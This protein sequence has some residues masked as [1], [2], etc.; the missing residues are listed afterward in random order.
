MFGSSCN[1]SR[2]PFPSLE[3]AAAVISA[4]VTGPKLTFVGSGSTSPFASLAS[5][6][7][8]AGTGISGSGFGSTLPVGKPL[9]NFAAPGGKPLH[10]EKPVKPFGAPESDS[11]NDDDDFDGGE[12]NPVHNEAERAVSPEKDPEERK[13]TKLHKGLFRV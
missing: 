3:P 12:E 6:S 7:N 11:E 4:A 13:R 2:S 9:L 5:A 1:S 8:G 10:R